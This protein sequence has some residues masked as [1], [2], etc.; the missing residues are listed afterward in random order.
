MEFPIQ[1]NLDSIDNMKFHKRDEIFCVSYK[2]LYFCKNLYR[3]IMYSL[4]PFAETIINTIV[5]SL[6]HDKIIL[7]GSYAKGSN[8][9]NSDIDILVLKKGLKNEREIM[10]SLYYEFFNKKIP[11]PIDLIAMDYDKFYQLNNDLG[12]I[13][14]TINQE[15]RVIYEQ[16]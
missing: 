2:I 6:S 16:L 11:V 12:Y 8:T 4:I 10:S 3:K 7:F 9:E 5:F 14:K 13:Y 1:I 15:G